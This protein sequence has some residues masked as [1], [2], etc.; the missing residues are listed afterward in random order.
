MIDRKDFERLRALKQELQTIEKRIRRTPNTELLGDTY[1]DYR[2]GYKHIRMIQGKSNDRKRRLEERY[3]AKAGELVA[4]IEQTEEAMEQI[5]DP[6]I[7]DIFRLYYQEGLS[8][9]AVADLKGYSRPRISQLI[10]E[11]WKEDKD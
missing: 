3:E 7:R 11:F 1:G 8:E 6:V 2:T 5:D 4:R 9:E 10:N